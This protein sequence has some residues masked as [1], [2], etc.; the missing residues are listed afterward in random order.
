MGTSLVRKKCRT[1]D[2]FFNRR[3]E[4]WALGAKAASVPTLTSLGSAAG[5]SVAGGFALAAAALV[6]ALVARC[7][8]TGRSVI[9]AP[10]SGSLA[11]SRL[12]TV[13]PV[14]AGNVRRLRQ[15]VRLG[16]T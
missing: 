5:V 16:Q 9:A 13:F 6:A 11:E 4:D 14:R 15:V 8:R 1:S 7:V 2:M 3:R 12:P 10:R